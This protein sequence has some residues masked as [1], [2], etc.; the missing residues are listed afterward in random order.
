MEDQRAEEIWWENEIRSGRDPSK[1]GRCPME[2]PALVY[3]SQYMPFELSLEH[4]N[5][6]FINNIVRLKLKILN[7]K[8]TS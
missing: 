6:E 4:K 5:N 2:I 1:Y 8:G 3:P 7:D